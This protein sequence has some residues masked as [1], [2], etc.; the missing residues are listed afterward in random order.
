M[1]KDPYIFGQKATKAKEEEKYSAI[2]LGDQ[3][4]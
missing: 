3:Q 1:D 4:V 2:S